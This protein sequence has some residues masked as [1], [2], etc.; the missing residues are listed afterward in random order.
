ME[1]FTE[2]Y[3]VRKNKDISKTIALCVELNVYMYIFSILCTSMNQTHINFCRHHKYYYIPSK[4]QRR[5][6]FLGIRHFY[7]KDRIMESGFAYAKEGIL[8]SAY[9]G[10]TS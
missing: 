1:K 6:N 8:F 5:F 10:F 7:S 9:M 2:F 3:K 4:C